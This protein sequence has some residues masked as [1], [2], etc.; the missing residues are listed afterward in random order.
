MAHFAKVIDGIVSQVIVAEPDFFDTFIDTSAGEWIKTSYNTLGGLHSE[1]KEPLRK[2]FAGV[3]HSYDKERDAFIAPKPYPS[4]TLDEATC[5]WEAPVP[6]PLD[7]DVSWNEET[8]S[9]E[10]NV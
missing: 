1:K 4:W 6:C 2:N 7:E 8:L 10:A 3:G 9:W 5:T